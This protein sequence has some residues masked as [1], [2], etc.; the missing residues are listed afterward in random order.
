MDIH[1]PNS[2]FLGNI[3]SFTSKFNP[4]NTSVLNVTSNQK[5]ISIHPLVI[6]MIVALA[7]EMEITG[8]FIN[9][10]DFSAKSRPY[11][12]RMGLIN[13]LK[14]HHGLQINEHESSG[15]FIPAR[16]IK[17]SDELNQFIIDM[18]PLLHTTP[19][20]AFPIKYVISE[21][22]R[23]VLEHSE[24]EIGAIVSAQ[25][26]KKSNRISIGVADRGIG[27]KASMN[28]SYATK[29]DKEAVD[30]ALRPGITG[31]TNKVGGTEFNAGAGLFFTKSIA[32]VSRDLFLLYSGNS[33]SSYIKH[34]L[35]SMLIYFLIQPLI[36][37]LL[38]QMLLNGMEQQ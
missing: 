38:D 20:Q 16:Q 25:Y 17:T 27:I 7:K 11:L 19:E 30:L 24:S 8:G 10:E 13:H 29:N 1:V 18:V 22:V 32:K 5:W 21:L 35:T 31:T 9:C 6:S 33:F 28:K 36:E 15:R 37:P 12:L 2:A 23:N 26:F 4:L 3:E 34:R 14:P